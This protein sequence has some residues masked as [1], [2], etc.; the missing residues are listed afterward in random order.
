MAWKQAA[1]VS[2]IDAPPAQVLGPN[3]AVR[4]AVFQA[5]ANLGARQFYS[6]RRNGL[7]VAGYVENNLGEAPG[8][9]DILDPLVPRRNRGFEISDVEALLIVGLCNYAFGIHD[10]VVPNDWTTLVGLGFECASDYVLKTFLKDAPAGV[11]RVVHQTATGYLLNVEHEL[12]I[13]VDGYKKKIFW[14]IDR[15]LVDSYT[16]LV[17]LDQMGGNNVTTSLRL[18]MRGLVPAGADLTMYIL[19]GEVRTPVLSLLETSS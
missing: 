11:P 9:H 16:P 7:G 2:K 12:T 1:I 3:D 18:R 6:M 15:V 17:P 13:V 19:G 14:Y 8:I 5:P 10:L 4:T